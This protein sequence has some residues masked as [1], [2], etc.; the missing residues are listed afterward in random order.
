MPTSTG[1]FT[2]EEAVPQHYPHSEVLAVKLTHAIF[3]KRKPVL[4][5]GCGDA[6]YLKQLFDHDFG[7]FGFDGHLPQHSYMPTFDDIYQADLSQEFNFTGV[8]RTIRGQVLSLEVG[9]HIPQEFQDTFIDNLVRHC[10]SKMVISW[11]MPGQNGIGHVNCQTND[12][13]IKQ[14]TK[15]GFAYNEPQTNYLRDGVEM[16]VNYFKNTIMVFDKIKG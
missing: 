8:R 12:Y 16:H 7:V 10:D 15:R 3:D 14:V 13:I 9:E 11:A 6:Y 2:P 1:I 5:F 4:D